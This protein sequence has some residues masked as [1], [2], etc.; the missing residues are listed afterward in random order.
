MV[1]GAERTLGLILACRKELPLL[2]RAGAWD[3]DGKQ[4]G[5]LLHG[6]HVLLAG[7]TG[8][9]AL[10]RVLAPTGAHVARP[11]DPAAP[12]QG[13]V[14]V[15]DVLVLLPGAAPLPADLLAALPDAASVVDVS[16]SGAVDVDLLA[17]GLA[18]GR[19]LHAALVADATT[20]PA[21]HALWRSPGVLVVPEERA[22]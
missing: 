20:L 16:G 7:T 5:R 6:A 14:A 18:A 1:G 21:G 3:P 9:E 11:V 13:E 12:A 10:T 17:A 22:A 2:L 15:A 4:R 8:V 19:P